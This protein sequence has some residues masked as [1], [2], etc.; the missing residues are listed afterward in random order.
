MN[1]DTCMDKE[2][3]CLQSKQTYLDLNPG[4][5]W[6]E[7]VAYL[8]HKFIGHEVECPLA[9]WFEDDQ[10]VRE[11]EIPAGA[12]FIGREH[13]LGHLTQVYRGKM[14]F[15]TETER[16]I[17]EPPFVLYT[18]P[19]FQMVCFTLTELIGRTYHPNSEG[20]KNAKTL[21]D[22]FFRPAA[23]VFELGRRIAER[24]VTGY[25]PGALQ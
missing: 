6:K 21:E 4:L 13:T 18:K 9:Q 3:T 5:S 15:I 22:R 17:V 25:L 2:I 23:E 12:Y 11:I 8:A 10:Y 24:Q 1:F 7:K 19:S 14:V 16:R 20:L